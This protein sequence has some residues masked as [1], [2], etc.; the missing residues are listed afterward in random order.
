MLA[1]KHRL[2]MPFLLFLSDSGVNYVKGIE[3]NITGVQEDCV[4]CVFF[5]ARVCR[6]GG[7]RRSLSWYWSL[8]G[9][10]VCSR[11]NG[12]QGEVVLSV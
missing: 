1:A 12:Q 10:L 11:G 3:Y 7:R 8:L 9:G 2:L 4:L 5:G 6:N